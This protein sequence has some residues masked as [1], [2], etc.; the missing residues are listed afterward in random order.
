MAKLISFTQNDAGM[1]IKSVIRD[2]KNNPLKIDYK[3]KVNA[4]IQFPNGDCVDVKKDCITVIDREE[5]TVLFTVNEEYT[6]QDGFYQVFLEVETDNYRLSTTKAI[7][8]FVNQ[9]HNKGLH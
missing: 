9:R 7:E 2:N 1:L 6:E 3:D 4:H 5:L 8:Y